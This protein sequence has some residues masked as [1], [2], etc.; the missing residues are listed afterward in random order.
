MWRAEEKL[1]LIFYNL[2]GCTALIVIVIRKEILGKKIIN[3]SSLNYF[4][5]LRTHT[6]KKQ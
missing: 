1:I 5:R 4:F 3:E 2:K 6:F